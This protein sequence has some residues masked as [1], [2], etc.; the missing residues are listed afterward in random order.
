LKKTT[1]LSGNNGLNRIATL[2]IV[3]IFAL[4]L[5]FSFLGCKGSEGE[6]GAAGTNGTNGTDGN[7]GTN[8]GDLILPISLVQGAGHYSPYE[9]QEVTVQGIVISPN[10]SGRFYIQSEDSSA[11]NDDDTSEGLY[12]YYGKDAD[13]NN[14][15]AAEGDLVKVKGIVEEYYAKTGDEFMGLSMTQIVDPVVTVISSGNTLPA[16]TVMGDGG[17]SL[18]E[19]IID[20]DTNGQIFNTSFDSDE[21]GID[22]FESLEGMLVHINNPA[23]VGSND[24]GSITVVADSGTNTSGMNTRGGITISEED[25][26]PERIILDDHYQSSEP[27]VNVGATFDASIDGIMSYVSGTYDNH[28]KVLVK[29]WPDAT[30]DTLTPETTALEAT[31]DYFTIATYNV[32]NLAGTD[33]ISDFDAHAAVIVNNLLNPDIIALQEM[34]DNDGSS[35]ETSVVSASTTFE[36]LIDSIEE[37]AGGDASYDYA[38]IDPVNLN[39]GGKPNLNIRVGFLYRTDRG[40]TFPARGGSGDATTD[41]PIDD[42]GATPELT[43]NPGRILDPH[44]LYDPT[45]DVFEITRRSLIAEFTF[46]GHQLFVVNNHFKSKSGDEPLYG[47]NQ[48]VTRSSES[49]RN[50]QAALIHSRV[51]EIIDASSDAKVIVLGDFND[52]QFSDA[53]DALKGDPQI[54]YD[55]I[56]NLPPNEQYTYIYKGNSQALDHILV[57]DSLRNNS[58]ASVDIVHV[59]S[60]FLYF[61]RASDHDPVIARYYLP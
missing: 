22:F 57:S 48:P 3:S 26:N 44:R 28:F 9:G 14:S 39:E 24:Y 19:E 52:F 27:N 7:D 33:S 45:S 13:G 29:D 17:R 10:K 38:Q 58:D 40:I 34:G 50:P 54:L 53:M 41:N 46:N 23:V 5:S 12:I 51:K 25:Y 56:E 1:R 61:N 21:D 37:A 4:T 31:S 36:R 15:P 35:S 8:A 60:E 55:E 2:V 6:D 32:Y 18:P 11:D 20:N 59:N 49:I 42:S 43:Y 30:G 47:Q 16:A